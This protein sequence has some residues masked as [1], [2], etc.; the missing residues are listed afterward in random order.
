MGSD[1]CECKVEQ[2]DDQDNLGEQ[3]VE[4]DSKETGSEETGSEEES[5]V[6]SDDGDE[7]GE[8]S[9]GS[10]G[11]E[12]PINCTADTAQLALGPPNVGGHTEANEANNTKSMM[13]S[14]TLD[15]KK[16]GQQ[17][18]EALAIPE[19]VASAEVQKL[20]GI[21]ASDL[22]GIK[23]KLGNAPTRADVS[24]EDIEAIKARLAQLEA[25]FACE[26]KKKKPPPPNHINEGWWYESMMPEEDEPHRRMVRSI[27]KASGNTSVS[28]G[29]WAMA[30]EHYYSAMELCPP[31]LPEL[32]TLH[33]NCSLCCLKQDKSIEAL[34]HA[35]AAVRLRPEWP[36]GHGRRGAALEASGKLEEAREAYHSALQLCRG[37]SDEYE[38]AI[39]R[40]RQRERAEDGERIVEVEPLPQE[41]EA[42]RVVEFHTPVAG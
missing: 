20:D 40:L 23:A 27:A 25:E 1:G 31:G 12:R 41:G 18:A 6:G 42:P 19:E 30:L 39:A 32:G 14:E 15:A 2:I 13:A 17:V 3:N 21:T 26:P 22:A 4:K 10:E 35:D 33:S 29:D 28:E 38:E 34:E 7:D 5:E 9:D 37:P 36:K 11:E 16:W 8:G 24:T